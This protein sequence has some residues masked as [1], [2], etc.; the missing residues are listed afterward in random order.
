[1]AQLDLCLFSTVLA[2][3]ILF[4]FDIRM[5]IADSFILEDISILNE[6][7]FLSCLRRQTR[8][9]LS[10]ENLISTLTQMARFAAS[11]VVWMKDGKNS[12]RDSSIVSK[13]YV[14][15]K[16]SALQRGC[17]ENQIRRIND[18][19]YSVT[20]D[21]QTL[22]EFL[23]FFMGVAPTINFLVSSMRVCQE[24]IWRILSLSSEFCRMS[25]DQKR[26]IWQ[27]SA[28][29]GVA[30]MMVR[31]ECTAKGIDQIRVI[32]TFMSP[33]SPIFH[34]VSTVSS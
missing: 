5:N 18:A 8:P 13:S 26:V 1:M 22:K 4:D 28:P 9:E 31:K 11:S 16:L 2:Y 14:T 7:L 19:F 23:M 34:I 27:R 20:H 21:E 10:V 6:I 29:T 3:I 12:F 24:R 32:T 17:L 33:V 25:Q 30:F 15:L